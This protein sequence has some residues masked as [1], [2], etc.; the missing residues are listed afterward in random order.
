[1]LPLLPAQSM[2]VITTMRF[3]FNVCAI[4]NPWFPIARDVR[5]RL[6]G[7]LRSFPLR[8]LSLESRSLK[9]FSRSAHHAD[10]LKTHPTDVVLDA[11]LNSDGAV[12]SHF[13]TTPLIWVRAIEIRAPC[14]CSHASGCRSETIVVETCKQSPEECSLE[15]SD[16]HTGFPKACSGAPRSNHDR[17]QSPGPPS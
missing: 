12:R 17:E 7:S 4:C 2:L 1:M 8:F 11:V 6:R 13:P 15:P 5:L 16:N 3:D 10:N 14:G 9:R